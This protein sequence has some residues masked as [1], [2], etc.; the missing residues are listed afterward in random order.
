MTTRKLNRVKKNQANGRSR[1]ASALRK[2]KLRI[3]AAAA[4]ASVALAQSAS[5]ATF[6]Y[7]PNNAA[8]DLWSTTPNWAASPPVSAATTELTFVGSNATVLADGLT[9]T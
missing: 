8:T 2:S 5:A 3:L 6:V 9:N 4:V 7:T 1:T